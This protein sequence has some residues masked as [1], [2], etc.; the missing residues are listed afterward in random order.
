MCAKWSSG[1]MLFL[2]LFVV[3]AVWQAAATYD[4]DLDLVQD[5]RDRLMAGGEPTYSIEWWDANGDSPGM[6]N[7]I[8]DAAEFILLETILED[9]TIDLTA[10]GGVSHGAVHAAW[11]ANLAQITI[12]M[13]PISDIEGAANWATA[14][15]TVSGEAGY[16]RVRQ[17]AAN[18]GVTLSDA[19]NFDL[20]VGDAFLNAPQDADGDGYTNLTE[21]ENVA[22]AYAGF[23]IVTVGKRYA[24]AALD[25]SASGVPKWDQWPVFRV[26]TPPVIDGVIDPDDYGSSVLLLTADAMA[27]NGGSAIAWD[28]LGGSAVIGSGFD[29]S[30]Q[31]EFYFAWDEDWL[32]VAARVS[33]D[34]VVYNTDS[35]PDNDVPLGNT[36]GIR[37]CTDHQNLND[38][39][40]ANEDNGV[41][42]HDWAPGQLSDPAAPAYYQHWGMPR[43]TFANTQFAA[44]TIEPGYEIEAAIKWSDFT[45]N[46][47]APSEGM[48]M[49]YMAMIMDYDPEA[50][51]MWFNAGDGTDII[52]GPVSAWPKLV[53]EPANPLQH[54][55]P[56]VWRF[57]C[58]LEGWVSN[59]SVD[60]DHTVGRMI[61][62]PI[63]TDPYASGESLVHA[64][65]MQEF[66]AQIAMQNAPQGG[67]LECAL[68]WWDSSGNYAYALFDLFAGQNELRFNIPAAKDGGT[69]AWE[70]VIYGIRLDMPQEAQSA[71]EAGTVFLVDVVAISDDPNFDPGTWDSDSDCDGD[72]LL[73]IEED[74]LGTDPGSSDTDGDG[75]DDAAE[76]NT[77][78]T[79]PTRADTDSDGLSDAA[80][81]GT[82]GTDPNMADTDGD[83][84]S[85]GLEVIYGT[86]PLD[87]ASAPGLPLAGWAGLLI[88]IF[89][90][91][92]AGTALT[93]RGHAKTRI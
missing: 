28:G 93:L 31:G 91:S 20:T 64:S 67:P 5:F 88:A 70:G 9:S 2:I 85:D 74:A 52:A 90:I 41:N 62:T 25:P 10:S 69:A 26:P 86:D 24:A 45:P 53:L 35:S 47:P 17:I 33:D 4:E 61:Y 46:A 65:L 50:H 77:Y 54:P 6:P 48:V 66:Y 84:V 29:T 22:A 34:N 87:A 16:K 44:R 78:G 36:D 3:G 37:F 1:K 13:E 7:G 75:L 80:E 73:N 32:Y 23:D 43:A 57:D 76:L 42:I 92:A 81:I 18:A 19:S 27:A 82:H 11:L 56:A 63:E 39:T 55:Q 68:Y 21:Y 51:E 60:L 38:A 49:G 30:I 79:N 59:D 14:L 83:G 71:I 89:A 8:P 15:I 58:D 72:G 40:L 12:D